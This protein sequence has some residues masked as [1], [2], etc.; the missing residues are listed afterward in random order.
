MSPKRRTFLSLVFACI[1]IIKQTYDM[2]KENLGDIISI[3]SQ[4]LMVIKR[5]VWKVVMRIDAKSLR[6]SFLSSAIGSKCS[7]KIV[8]LMK[9]NFKFFS[10]SNAKPKP[11]VN[12]PALTTVARFLMRVFIGL[13]KAVFVFQVR[14]IGNAFYD[15]RNSSA[16]LL[17]CS[18]L[19]LNFIADPFM[20][21]LTRKQYRQVL[22]I[23]FT[24]RCKG[25]PD[26]RVFPLNVQR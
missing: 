17:V 8:Q 18:F 12:F 5:N 19:M 3:R 2:N 24:C 7:C 15:W 20:Y 11:T 14:L 23:I 25:R 16:D 6:F 4:F 9:A 26:D 22:K 10:Q 13:F 21:V 1:C